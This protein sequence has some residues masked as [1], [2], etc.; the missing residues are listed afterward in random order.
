MNAFRTIVI[1]AALGFT[2]PALAQTT[3]SGTASTA[4]DTEALRQKLKAD[5]KLVVSQNMKLTEAEAKAFWP[6]YDAYQKGLA[7]VNERIRKTVIAYAD[8]QNKGTVS[9]DVARKLS[10]DAIAADEAEIKL[11]RAMLPKLEKAVGGMKAARYL[12]IENKVRALVK[13][14]LADAIPLVH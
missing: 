4:S 11:K 8:A 10:E 12:Q 2:L 5:K 9:S 6:L 13:L 1:A 3:P 7:D 14:E